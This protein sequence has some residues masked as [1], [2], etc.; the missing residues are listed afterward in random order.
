MIVVLFL[1]TALGGVFLLALAG[2]RAN[3]D[4][5]THDINK[6]LDKFGFKATAI[7]SIPKPPGLK[8]EV[9]SSFFNELSGSTPNFLFKR[10]DYLDKE[11]Q[12]K[13]CFAKIKLRPLFGIS[14][15]IYWPE[16]DS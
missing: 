10:V 14:V 4:K 3:E 5:Y 6:D 15:K 13:Y 11:G 2:R 7:T 9:D 16:H 12:Q 8:E 1:I